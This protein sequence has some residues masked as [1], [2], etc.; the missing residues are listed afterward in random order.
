MSGNPTIGLEIKLPI[1]VEVDGV[2]HNR[3]FI[4][5]MCGVDEENLASPTV[6]NNSSKANTV[7][8]Q[9]LIQSIP[10]LLETK[11]NRYG[12]IPDELVRN[13]YQADRDA[14]VIGMLQQSP[15]PT[16]DEVATCPW[17]Q[18]QQPPRHVD[19]RELGIKE[20]PADKAAEFPIELRRGVMED[21][22]TYTSGFFRFP[23]GKDV[24]EVGSVQGNMADAQTR[25]YFRCLNINTDHFILSKEHV[26]QMSKYDRDYLGFMLQKHAPGYETTYET[27]CVG[28]GKKI[29]GSIDIAAF[30]DTTRDFNFG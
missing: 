24:E 10:G 21:G 12:L 26:R 23:K 13:M 11:D 14:A 22:V 4:D 28:C 3:M 16:N 1:G 7:L 27:Q 17:C 8:L 25:L 20:W 9:R 19:L 29:E 2:R 15:N 18:T 6:R 5:E 30:F